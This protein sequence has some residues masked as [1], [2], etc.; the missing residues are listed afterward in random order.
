MAGCPGLDPLLRVI[1]LVECEGSAASLKQDDT[2]TLD[3]HI[4][5]TRDSARCPPAAVPI[6][7]PSAMA[8]PLD[9][10]VFQAYKSLA[11]FATSWL[12]LLYVVRSWTVRVHSSV[13]ATT[14]WGRLGLPALPGERCIAGARNSC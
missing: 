9:P 10:V 4:S 14:H 13:L 1:R 11:C 6:R 5:L 8:S 3:S 7:M 2:C 12:V